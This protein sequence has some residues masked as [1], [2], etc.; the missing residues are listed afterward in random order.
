MSGSRLPSFLHV[1][2][3]WL[4]MASQ[5]EIGLSRLRAHRFPDHY[6]KRAGATSRS[7]S[8]IWMTDRACESTEAGITQ[9]TSSIFPGSNDAIQ[10]TSEIAFSPSDKSPLI[11]QRS[12]DSREAEAKEVKIPTR[13]QRASI[14]WTL[15]RLSLLGLVAFLI[16]LIAALEVLHY[17]SNKNLGLVTTDPTNPDATY[18]WKYLPTASETSGPHQGNT[19]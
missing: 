5:E 18:Y 16:A 15:R 4:T 12:A 14:P 1:N 9:H 3:C 7:V 11:P 2:F 13:N 17:F 10:D 8:Q 19:I 6:A